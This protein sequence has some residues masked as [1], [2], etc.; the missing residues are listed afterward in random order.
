MHEGDK[1]EIDK[2]TNL[3]INYLS[4]VNAYDSSCPP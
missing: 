3:I 4:Y 1:E 2:F